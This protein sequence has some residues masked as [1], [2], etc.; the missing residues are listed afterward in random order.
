M[1]ALF[2]DF[3]AFHFTT[4]IVFIV[5]KCMIL[6]GG[7]RRGGGWIYNYLCNITL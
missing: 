4:N 7:G 2:Y 1:F 6:W 3:F 5:Y